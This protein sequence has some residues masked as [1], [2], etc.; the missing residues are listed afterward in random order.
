VLV[1]AKIAEEMGFEVSIVD[2]EFRDIDFEKQFEI[3]SFYLVTPNAKYA[4]DLADKFHEIGSYIVMG[5]VHASLMQDEVKSHCDTL[6]VGEGEYIFRQFLIDFK[7]SRAKKKY[8][9]K[10]GMVQ[11]EDSPIPAYHMLN[12]AEQQLVPIQTA[13]GCSHHCKFCNVRGLYGSQFRSKSKKQ[14]RKEL[15]EIS[16]LPYA[17]KVYVTDDNIMSSKKHFEEICDI[18]SENQLT[19]YANTDIKF[20]ENEENIK[21]AY[22]SG[23]RQVLIGFESAESRNLYKL[24]MDNF[25][26]KYSNKYKDFIKRIQSYG[27]GITGS[28]IVGYEDD[29]LDTFKYLEEFIFETCLY[30]VNITFMTPYPETVLF[31]KL[32]EENKI[33]TFD[34][35]FY[36]IFQPVVKLNTLSISQLNTSYCQLINKINSSEYQTHKLNYFKKIYK[37]MIM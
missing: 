23:L 18:F 27:I 5:G 7:N 36:T 1:L 22:Q 8:I 14:I 20:A 10:S 6:M 19:W 16:K 32:K 37:E 35:N 24:D 4:Y 17:R 31:S 2:E 25:K 11:L 21:K 26:Y 12:K 13:R 9:Q 30:G 28:F 33:L 29:T 34:W 15:E 3:V